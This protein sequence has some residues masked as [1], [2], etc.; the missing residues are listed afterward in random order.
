MNSV[1]HRFPD[2]PPRPR[3][4]LRAVLIRPGGLSDEEGRALAQVFADVIHQVW[5]DAEDLQVSAAERVSSIAF[6][7]LATT[8][9][10]WSNARAREVLEQT[11][12]EL[13]RTPGALG[14]P[15]ASAPSMQLICSRRN[16]KGEITQGT[17]LYIHSGQPI[18]GDVAFQVS[19]SAL[20]D[21]A[22][23]EDGDTARLMELM[24]HSGAQLDL[25][26]CLEMKVLQAGVR[27][28]RSRL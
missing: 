24:A 14:A 8:S 23:Y 5:A 7:V 21:G 15:S 16:D 2:S 6:D 3:L 10:S 28:P 18:K 27:L 25:A 22:L 20:E 26:T 9:S 13:V 19:C 11:L 12:I 1:A 4:T 17:S